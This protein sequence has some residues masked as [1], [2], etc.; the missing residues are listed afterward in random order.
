MLRTVRPALGSDRPAILDVCEAAFVTEP[1]FHHFFADAYTPHAR[2]FLAYLLDL[3]LESGL[4]W[5]AE[6]DG[7]VVAASLWNPPG[8]VQEPQVDQDARWA[9]TSAQFPPPVA[10]RL[11]R[12]D[13]LVHG[14]EPSTPHY[15]LGVIASHPDVR[16]SGHGA[17]V[18]HPGIEAADR[19]AM[20]VFLETGTE[21]NLAFYGRFGFAVTDQVALDD[22]TR[23]WCLT[24]PSD[25]DPASLG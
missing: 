22:G 19:S 5:V 24:R 11:E 7:R 2:T 10:S 9:A 6:T 21:G 8:G 14:Y 4:V 17:A 12:Y 20:P 23:I 13:G 25:A 18:L 15:Y 1:A 16:G 3:R